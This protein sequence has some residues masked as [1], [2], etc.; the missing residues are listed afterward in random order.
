LSALSSPQWRV[1]QGWRRVIRLQEASPAAIQIPIRPRA[2]PFHYPH[3]LYAV[4]IYILLLAL[5]DA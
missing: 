5:L 4:K 3:A 2:W 1:Q